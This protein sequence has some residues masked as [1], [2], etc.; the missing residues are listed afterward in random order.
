MYNCVQIIEHDA[1]V[2]LGRPNG[3]LVIF[4]I[5][6][7]N[8]EQLGISCNKKMLAIKIIPENI[9][10]ISFNEYLLCVSNA[11]DYIGEIIQS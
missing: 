1:V 3:R 8:V 9:N 2:N 7:L 11:N 6:Q 4:Y 5:S 10:F